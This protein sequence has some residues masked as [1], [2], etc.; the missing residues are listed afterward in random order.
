MLK[1]LDYVQKRTVSTV[2][3]YNEFKRNI[4]TIEND[5]KIDSSII[6]MPNDK[7]DDFEL[8]HICNYDTVLSKLYD[9]YFN[10][11]NIAI[12]PLEINITARKILESQDKHLITCF[13]R[14]AELS[15]EYNLLAKINLC[16]N[17]KQIGDFANKFNA[18]FDRYV[19][20]GG[21]VYT[22]CKCN[23]L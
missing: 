14:I 11:L 16:R 5:N 2:D 1:Y 6:Y 3:S 9:A 21:D 23:I 17:Q 19:E 7:Y 15:S 12:V 8:E 18:I 13:T 22:S 10:Y 4:N 20:L